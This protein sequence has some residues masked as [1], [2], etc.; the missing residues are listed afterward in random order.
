[1]SSPFDHIK[2]HTIRGKRWKVS[3]RKP[4]E[5]CPDKTSH[6]VGMCESPHSKGRTLT[7]WPKQ[8]GVELLGCIAHELAHGAFWDLDEDAVDTFEK[9]FV[10]LLRRMG[11][12]VTFPS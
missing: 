7:I 3:W 9:S 5:R 11:A 12:K 2:H 8:E 1:M 10:L 6:Y 4:R